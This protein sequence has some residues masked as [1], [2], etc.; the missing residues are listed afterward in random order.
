MFIAIRSEGGIL[1]ILVAR[2]REGV[3]W[4]DAVYQVCLQLKNSE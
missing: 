3:S 2:D 1:G 4:V